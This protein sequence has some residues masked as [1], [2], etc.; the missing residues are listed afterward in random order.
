MVYKLGDTTV[1]SEADCV[2]IAVMDTAQTIKKS[3]DY[4]AIGI[5]DITPHS[6]VIAVD[7]IR[8][9][10]EQIDHF[11]LVE[12][13]QA[14]YKPTYFVIE[15][16]KGSMQLIQECQRKGIPVIA[17]N[18]IT[19][20]RLRGLSASPKVEAGK[21]WIPQS[22]PWVKDFLEE[23]S[24]YPDGRHDD[25]ADTAVYAIIHT[26]QANLAGRQPVKRDL[27]TPWTRFVAAANA[28]KS[29]RKTSETMGKI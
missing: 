13:A 12:H 25:M 21:F 19:D 6:D 3:S 7:V 8:M 10:A 20:K 24:S 15:K 18:P 4:T 28:F 14:T 2:R 9:K 27:T 11:S 23:I 17:V 26:N 29:D 5:Y 16:E 1:F 22:A